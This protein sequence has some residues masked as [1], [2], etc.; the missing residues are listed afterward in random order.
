M[1]KKG[2][3]VYFR[4]RAEQE[5]GRLVGTYIK[6]RDKYKG[7]TRQQIYEYT[8]EWKIGIINTRDQ[9][10]DFDIIVVSPDFKE[11][12]RKYLGTIASDPFELDEMG[13]RLQRDGFTRSILIRKYWPSA[14]SASGEYNL[15]FGNKNGEYVWR[16]VE[17]SG[18]DATTVT[19][20]DSKQVY[21]LFQH[22]D[23]DENTN[24]EDYILQYSPLPSPDLPAG[25]HYIITTTTFPSPAVYKVAG[26]GIEEIRKTTTPRSINFKVLETRYDRFGEMIE[27]KEIYRYNYSRPPSYFFDKW[28]THGAVPSLQIEA[29]EELILLTYEDK[30]RFPVLNTTNS[31]AF[32]ALLTYHLAILT[33][34]QERTETAGTVTWTGFAFMKDDKGTHQVPLRN[35]GEGTDYLKVISQS[36]YSTWPTG[37]PERWDAITRQFYF[38]IEQVS[39]M[40]SEASPSIMKKNDAYEFMVSGYD[41]CFIWKDGKEYVL[42]VKKEYEING[43]K[44]VVED[45]LRFDY[46]FNVGAELIENPPRFADF[47]FHFQSHYMGEGWVANPPPDEANP[48]LSIDMLRNDGFLE[49]GWYHQSSTWYGDY[50][51]KVRVDEL[52]DGTFFSDIV[53]QNNYPVEY[54]FIANIDFKRDLK[55]YRP[56]TTFLWVEKYKVSLDES[57]KT[58]N[59][60]Y[61]R[62]F[63]V[64]FKPPV[65]EVLPPYPKD[66]TDDN[67]IP[68][69]RDIQLCAI[70]YIP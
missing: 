14:L 60:E 70:S 50:I 22:I 31:S 47:V 61:I 7:W 20:V 12:G 42:P 15:Y 59:I 18:G 67:Q 32:Y 24:E 23:I 52:F 33:A 54:D 63:S 5:Q 41:K 4:F 45:R 26:F 62:R 8:R 48:R 19:V 6:L 27:E 57:N 2:D 11:D 13:D 3:K 16:R 30:V 66:I 43:V 17:A 29:G 40:W 10:E 34:V 38:S 58:A 25:P 44:W 64:P 56:D 51:Y 55:I 68:T 65:E 49:S 69:E 53:I 46:W 28:L 37:M 39:G 9:R 36:N 21:I 35:E 1:A